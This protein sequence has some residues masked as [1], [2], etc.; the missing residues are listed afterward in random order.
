MKEENIHILVFI[1]ALT[2]FIVGIVL[3]LTFVSLH[4]KKTKY[5]EL[6]V[7]FKTFT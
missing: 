3:V 7:K 4:S 6:E 2:I 1:C 5:L